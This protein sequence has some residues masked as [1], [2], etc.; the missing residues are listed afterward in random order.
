MFR[1]TINRIHFVGIGGSG[2]SGIAEVLLTQG[3][4]VTGSDMKEGAAVTRLR[5]LGGT[6]FIGHAASHVDGV[7]VVV[8]STAVP[9]SNIEITAAAEA[10]IPVIPRAEMLA[11]LMRMKYGIAVAGTH[12][13]TTTTSMLATCLHHA[14]LDPTVVIGGRLNSMGSS[15]RLGAGEFMVAE[16]DE[17]DGSFMLLA[18]TVAIITNIDPEHMTHWGTE[19][20]LVDGF[21]DF[22]SKVPFFGFAV[23]CTDHPT[24]ATIAPWL[25][26]RV[27]TYGLNDGAEFQGVNLEN[28]GLSTSFSVVYRGEMLGRIQVAMPGHHNISNALATIAVAVNL[29]IPFATIAAALHNFTGVDR[30]FSIRAEVGPRDAPVTIIDDYGHHPVEI[31]A[32][33]SGVR[34][35]WPNRRVIAIFQ[36]HRYSRVADLFSEFCDSF[37]DADHVVVCPIY[38]AGEKPIHRISHSRI[39]D[40]LLE[41]GNTSISAID[42]LDDAVDHLHPRIRPGDVVVTLGAGDI[43]RICAPLAAR[44]EGGFAE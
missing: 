24:V 5:E 33:L 44:L 16:A 43:N 18:P 26:R 2:M 34:Q 15:A 10:G 42:S 4:T 23:L 37:S 12:G 30:R 7:D 14:G 3:Y 29:D 11:E 20:A 17:S 27:V 39:L 6:V 19:K 35:A 28:E 1:G 32:T 38:A 8:K 9:K 40:G 22:A 41:K 13:K 36:P 25:R 21:F 31:Q